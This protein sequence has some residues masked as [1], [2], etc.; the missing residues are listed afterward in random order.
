MRIILVQHAAVPSPAEEAALG[1][2]LHSVHS[3]KGAHQT[4]CSTLSSVPEQRHVGRNP[5]HAKAGSHIMP[6]QTWVKSM[7]GHTPLSLV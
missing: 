3:R 7:P 2:G 4:S 6:P 1:P 5:E